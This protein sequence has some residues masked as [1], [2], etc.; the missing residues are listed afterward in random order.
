MMSVLR[1]K[2]LDTRA[3]YKLRVSARPH[4]TQDGTVV[5]IC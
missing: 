3:R 4:G 5:S 1:A 2:S